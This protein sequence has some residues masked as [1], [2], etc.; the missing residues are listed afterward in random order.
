MGRWGVREIEIRRATC[1]NR[2][3]EREGDGMRR[4]WEGT[5]KGRGRVRYG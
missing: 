2:D 4:G 1:K 5:G 3:G